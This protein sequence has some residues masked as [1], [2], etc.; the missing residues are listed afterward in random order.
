MSERIGVI[1]LGRM[2]SALAER[3]ATQGATV[4]GWT[5]SGR[6]DITGARVVGS[7]EEVVNASDVLILS[8]FDDAA[9]GD[10][11][12]QLARLDLTRRLIVETST[13]APAVLRDAAPAIE[14]AGGR[15]IDAPISGGPEMVRAGTIG[16]FVGGA[17]EDVARFLPVAALLSPRVVPVGPLGAGYAA[18]IMNNVALGGAWQAMIESMR[19]GARLG[20]DLGTMVSIL[21][22]SPATNPS[23]RTRIPKILGEDGEVGFPVS[24]V[25]KD[26]DLFLRIA[27]SVGTSLPALS[28]ARASFG[29]AAAQGHGDADLA[30]VITANLREP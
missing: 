3:L 12:T 25:L 27:E 19:L 24:G 5:R 21:A 14:T 18:K 26:Q 10:V 15:V 23:F 11:L 20:L 29:H 16:L 7:L 22:D 13:V 2:G 6:V 8:L 17:E 30:R 28:A 9:V 1:G 4:T